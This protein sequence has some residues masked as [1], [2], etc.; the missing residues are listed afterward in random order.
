MCEYRSPAVTNALSRPVS[1]HFRPRLLLS[2]F[3]TWPTGYHGSTSA[4]SARESISAPFLTPALHASAKSSR[5]REI[6]YMR[7]FPGIITTLPKKT[8]TTR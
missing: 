5:R 1:Y 3:V 6:T 8:R 4:T 2:R 7:N